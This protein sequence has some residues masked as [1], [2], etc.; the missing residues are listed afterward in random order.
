MAFNQNLHT[1][2]TVTHTGME[3]LRV[4]ENSSCPQIG[5]ENILRSTVW[6]LFNCLST[7]WF[8]I[9][10]QKHWTASKTYTVKQLLFSVT[11]SLAF[12]QIRV[13]LERNSG[14][15]L[16]NPFPLGL[17]GRQLCIFPCWSSQMKTTSEASITTEFAVSTLKDQTET[18]N[19][20]M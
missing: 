1:A 12:F 11:Y 10:I 17:P 4:L 16:V 18:K 7:W 19:G 14:S 2:R 3:Q 6:M 13:E 15:H 9:S 20:C 8:R 5:W